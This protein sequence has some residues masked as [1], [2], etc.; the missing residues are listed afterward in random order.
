VTESSRQP[1]GLTDFLLFLMAVIWAINFSVVKYATTRF[2]PV[3]FMTIRIAFSAALL[4]VIALV[5]NPPKLTRGTWV[6]LLLLG[7]MGHGIYQYFFVIG[8]SHTRAGNAALIVAS[9]PAFIAIVSRLRGLEKVRRL[10]LAGIGLSVVGVVVVI[11]GSA[12]PASNEGSSALGTVL[13][14]CA[15]LSWTV[16]TVGLQPYT[17]LVP[18]TQLAAIT[19][20]GGAVPLLLLTIPQLRAENW[21]AVGAGGW[22]ALGYS[23][24]LSTVV[25]YFLWYHGLRKIGATRTSA[26]SNIQPIIALVVAWVFLNEAPTAWQLVGTGTIVSGIFLA[27]T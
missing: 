1:F 13:I 15:V 8:V 5:R 20:I 12:R 14:V 26:Y 16:F 4:A 2:D 23:S 25:G 24:V 18:S 19:I 17:R 10:V 6:R 7:V 22:L 9:A 3:V 21:S 11:L 27:R